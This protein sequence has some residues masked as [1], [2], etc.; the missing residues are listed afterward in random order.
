MGPAWAGGGGFGHS[1][2]GLV[3]PE[4]YP[5]PVVVGTALLVETN[6]ENRPGILEEQLDPSNSL[7]PGPRKARFAGRLEECVPE[8]PRSEPDV[9]PVERAN[10]L[11]AVAVLEPGATF[12]FCDSA[13]KQGERV[14]P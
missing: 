2:V 11:V 4:R 5:S 3:R 14:Q 6:E 10:S 7:R 1:E 12:G 8:A 9:Y 13:P